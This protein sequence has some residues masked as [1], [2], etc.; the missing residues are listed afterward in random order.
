MTTLWTVPD[1]LM[2]LEDL[3]DQDSETLQVIEDKVKAL[4]IDLDLRARRWDQ[5][6]RLIRAATEGEG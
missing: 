2:M 4:L 3:Y 1:A 5:M 6:E